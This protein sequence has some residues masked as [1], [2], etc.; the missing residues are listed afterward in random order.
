MEKEE[1]S[2]SE[3]GLKGNIYINH[4]QRHS[5]VYNMRRE[6][7]PISTPTTTKLLTSRNT[8]AS[9]LKPHTDS[10]SL[11]HHYAM[12]TF[13]SADN[14][15]QHAGHSF[16]C[17]SKT[18]VKHLMQHATCPHGTHATS[19]AFSQQITHFSSE[20]PPPSLPTPR[21]P[22][23]PIPTPPIPVAIKG[24]AEGVGLF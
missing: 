12:Y 8:S 6:L 2:Q 10:H 3:V 20:S 7:C 19:R 15:V 11:R 21:F 1:S 18:S 16:F 13:R 23:A 5:F 9:L 17:D 24:A 22:L 4:L 14:S